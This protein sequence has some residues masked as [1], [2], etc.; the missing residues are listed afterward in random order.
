MTLLRNIIC[1]ILLITLFFALGN[2]GLTMLNPLYW[3]IGF[4]AAILIHI[5]LNKAGM[6]NN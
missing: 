6:N 5:C 4:S 1:T 3:F 2:F